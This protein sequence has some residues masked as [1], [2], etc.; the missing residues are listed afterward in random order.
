[1]SG[2][3]TRE[4]ELLMADPRPENRPEIEPINVLV[5][6]ATTHEMPTPNSSENGRTSSRTPT[7]GMRL[8]GSPSDAF[9]AGES[10][11][12]R[13]YHSRPPAI[14]SGPATRN[15]RDPMR[16]AIVPIRVERT[17]SMIPIG[18]PTSPA[19]RAV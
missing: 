9:Q 4:I 13:E 8:A 16:P 12:R 1:M 18:S 6:G 15:R 5:S 10:T 11:G 14:S 17:D 3:P 2:W 7:G 19:P